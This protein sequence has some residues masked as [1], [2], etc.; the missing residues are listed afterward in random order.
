MENAAITEEE[1]RKTEALGSKE[2]TV[3]PGSVRD[4]FY[5][6]MDRFFA[7]RQAKAVGGANDLDSDIVE[8]EAALECINLFARKSQVWSL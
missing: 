5:R 1:M 2:C 6:D 4:S 8:F 7:R 3:D